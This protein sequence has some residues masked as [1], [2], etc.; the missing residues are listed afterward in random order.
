MRP[1]TLVAMYW[2]NAK[3]TVS[4]MVT[5]LLVLDRSATQWVAL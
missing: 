1:A 4:S 3:A 5:Q 2:A